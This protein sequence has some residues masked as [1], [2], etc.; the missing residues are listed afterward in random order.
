M[1]SAR[2]EVSPWIRGLGT[3]LIIVLPLVMVMG[4]RPYETVHASVTDF[5]LVFFLVSLAAQAG[6]I[7]RRWG[8]IR[9]LLL[10]I[11]L[12]VSA[13]AGIV[14]Y[15]VILMAMRRGGG[16]VNPSLVAVILAYLLALWSGQR[17]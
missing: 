5:A 17:G 15:E 14:S 13:A 16:M 9:I 12:L 6:L 4:I 11:D 10:V 3:L 2:R 1:R 8:N 7:V